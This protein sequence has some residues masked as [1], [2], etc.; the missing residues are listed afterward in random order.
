MGALEPRKGVH[1]WVWVRCFQ[2]HG[3]APIDTNVYVMGIWN[4]EIH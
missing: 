4:H 2:E 1:G 3:Y